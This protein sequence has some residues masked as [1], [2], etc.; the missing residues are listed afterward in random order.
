MNLTKRAVEQLAYEK[1]GDAADYRWDD[2][3]KGFGVRVYPSGRKTF[4]VTYRNAQGSK[5]FLRL[6]DFGRSR[7]SKP[8]SWRGRSW[9]TSFTAAIRRRSASRP[10]M[11][12]PSSSSPLATWST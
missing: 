8:G 4:L 7:S 5:R 9:Q 11:N 10:V 3:L 12:L 6:G 1:Q 2:K